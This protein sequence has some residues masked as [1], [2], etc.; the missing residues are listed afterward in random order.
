MRETRYAKLNKKQRE[1]LDAA[2]EI[3][4]RAYNPNSGFYVGA[5][6]RAHCGDIIP[7][8]NMENA[9]YSPTICA[10]RAAL[11]EANNRNH[12]MF[13][14]IA[15]IARGET[16]DTKEPTRPCGVCRQMLYE[17]SEL[18]QTDLEVICSTTDMKR[19]EIWTVNELLPGA[20]GQKDLGTDLSRY[21]I[22]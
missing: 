7:G 8:C 10:E 15:V 9:A 14:G 21:R 17:A 2:F 19:I 22:C 16:F 12:R 3:V 5:A 11:A 4:Q 20:F 18:S 6:L 1:L 13:R